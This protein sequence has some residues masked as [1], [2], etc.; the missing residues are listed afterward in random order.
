MN[1]QEFEKW[2]DTGEG[3][4]R[5]KQQTRQAERKEKPLIQKYMELQG[6]IKTLRQEWEKYKQ[7]LIAKYPAETG[8]KWKFIC[9]H[10]KKID[11][12]L[13]KRGHNHEV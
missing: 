1:K 13:S 10:H 7:F 6:E 3:S 8:K 4:E 12:I 2:Y 9:K 5:M 11:S